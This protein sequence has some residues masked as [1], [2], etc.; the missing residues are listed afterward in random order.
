[1]SEPQAC[2]RCGRELTDDAPRGLCPVCLIGAALATSEETHACGFKTG[3]DPDETTDPSEGRIEPSGN[4][5]STGTA[6]IPAAIRYFGDY[7]IQAEVGRGGM[8][9]VYRA[10]Q[11]SLN[12]PV[13]LKLIRAGVLAGDDELR[14]FQNEAEAVA[15]L[16]H[17]GIVPIHWVEATRI[18]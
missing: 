1:M 12:R 9:V 11:V 10:R 18:L 14:R 8:G 3:D 6:E 13:A 2:P 7:E 5:G 17:P 4:S 15:L 16:D